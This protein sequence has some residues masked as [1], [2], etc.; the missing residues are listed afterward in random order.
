MYR[1]SN[2]L[3]EY[4]WGSQSAI[5]N[6]F[7]WTPTGRPAAELWLGA[8]PLSPSLA[9]PQDLVSVDWLDFQPESLISDDSAGVSLISLIRADPEF[10]LGDAVEYAYG[11]RLPYLM[12]I[13]ASDAPLSLQVHPK[14]HVA[15]A[16]FLR[17]NAAGIDI[18]SSERNYKDDQH[19]PEMILALTAFEGLSGFRRPQRILDL[20]D[21]VAGE[22]AAQ[23]RSALRAAPGVAGVRSAFE[24]ALALRGTQCTAQLVEA[25]ESIKKIVAERTAL[26]ELVSRG[27]VTALDLFD[28][29]PGDPGALVSLMLNRF[30]L[31]P[32]Q[33][34]YLEAGQVHA[35]LGGLGVEIMASSDN[36]LRAGLT[37]KKVDVAELVQCTDF[38]PAPPA[39][40]AIRERDG[41]LREYRPDIAEFALL[42]GQVSGSVLVTHNGPRIVVCLSG[43]VEVT[44]ALGSLGRLTAGQSAFVPHGVGNIALH[45][46]CEAAISF[47]P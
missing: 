27:H 33:A 39:R 4:A 9:H 31:E 2:T 29:Y 38:A 30:S 17:E 11:P 1:L 6:K 37:P 8:H 5:F 16:G 26:G 7:G 10:M 15:R 21:G 43:E 42:Y 24:H 34:V 13:L 20:L 12:K 36:V 35:Y 23:M 40:P 28:R 22:C 44:N 25:Q 19:K 45:G 32:G 14:P 47:V 46:E 3:H 18:H 41:G